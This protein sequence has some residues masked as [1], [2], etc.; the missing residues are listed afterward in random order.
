MLQLG[1]IMGERDHVE[2]PREPL[3]KVDFED[4]S[5][6]KLPV[7]WEDVFMDRF[8]FNQEVYPA[9]I[10]RLMFVANKY[11]EH[12]AWP[13][14]LDGIFLG[15]REDELGESKYDTYDYYE[16][17][18][19]DW[20]EAGLEWGEERIFD[21]PTAAQVAKAVMYQQ[22]RIGIMQK[23]LDN[24]RE[25]YGGK[26]VQVLTPEGFAREIAAQGPTE[27]DEEMGDEKIENIDIH[28]INESELETLLKGA[29]EQADQITERRR[30]RGI[31]PKTRRD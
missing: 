15:E 12:Q 31:P 3:I 26:Y 28:P 29:F 14:K 25:Q 5:T 9:V 17:F 8:G 27:K 19:C 2:Q 22:L 7:D 4:G 1:Q 20:G 16:E 13:D 23:A 30:K 10:E 21:P 18:W 11:I 24:Y 6:F